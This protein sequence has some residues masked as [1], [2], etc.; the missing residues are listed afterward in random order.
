VG[1]GYGKAAAAVDLWGMGGTASTA[2]QRQASE[3]RV[4]RVQLKLD[5]PPGSRTKGAVRGLQVLSPGKQNFGQAALS[6]RERNAA[7]RTVAFQA[8][9]LQ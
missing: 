9:S 1:V 8:G 5:P 7:A 3:L 4:L 2:K 6:F